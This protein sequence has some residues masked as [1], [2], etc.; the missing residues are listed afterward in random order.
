MCECVFAC[1]RWWCVARLVVVFLVVLLSVAV[2]MTGLVG[3]AGVVEAAE[4]CGG[5]SIESHCFN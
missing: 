4:A 1:V 5:P 3:V 2:R